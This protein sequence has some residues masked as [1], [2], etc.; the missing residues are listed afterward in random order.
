MRKDRRIRNIYVID[1]DGKN[2]KQLTNNR[3]I[4]YQSKSPVWSPDG[5]KIAYVFSKP[6]RGPESTIIDRPAIIIMDANGRNRRSLVPYAHSPVWSPD[7]QKIVFLSDRD[8]DSEIYIIDADGEN[9][10]RL[11]KDYYRNTDPC[12]LVNSTNLRDD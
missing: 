9:M 2:L 4:N 10:K 5:T 6:D 12:W 11:T 8:G 3:R 7:G 1:A